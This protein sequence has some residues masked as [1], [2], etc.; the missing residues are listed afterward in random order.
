MII[1]PRQARDKHK[2]NSKIRPVRVSQVG[3]WYS[4]PAGVACK[5]NEK[6]GALRP[7]GSR[8]TWKQSQSARTMRGWQLYAAGLNASGLATERLAGCLT[9]APGCSPLA[10]Q[11]RENVAVMKSVLDSAPLAPWKCGNGR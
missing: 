6:L 4:H 5:S 9:N 8:C 7:D 2:G 11:I 1:L 10:A 3:R